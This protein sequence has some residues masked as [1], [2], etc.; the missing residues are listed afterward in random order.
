MIATTSSGRR[1]AALARYLMFGRSG[2]EPER[3]AWTA[4]R[5]V[6]TDDPE[7]AAALMQATANANLD[8]ESPVYHLTINFDPAD[9]VTP[10]R[11]QAV[12]DRVLA[13]LGLAEH[14]ALLVA[15]RDRSHPHVH[16]MVNRVHPETGRAWNRWQDRPRIERA[17][18]EL[19]R[20]LGLREVSGRLYQLDGQEPPERAPL[21]S[22]E[23]RQAER[24]GDPAFPDRVRAHLADLRAARSWEELEATLARHGL[25]LERKGQ[26]LVITDGKQQVKASRVARDLSLRRLEQ[27]FGVPYPEREPTARAREPLSRAV[28]QVTKA[29]DEHERLAALKAERARADQELAAA[30]ERLQRLNGAMERVRSASERFD[31]ALARVYK[32]PAAAR[33]RFTRTAVEIG[34]ER[35]ITLLGSEPEQFGALKTVERRRA[36]GLGVAH[37]TQPARLA[38]PSAAARARELAE[39]QHALG[40]LARSQ[41]DHTGAEHKGTE[42]EPERSAEA[43]RRQAESL[44]NKAAERLRRLQQQLKHAPSL[45]LLERSIGR[46]VDRLLP[47]EL[48]QLRRMITAP[49]AVIA[50]KA[51]EAVKDI[52]LGRE[53]GEE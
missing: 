5:N 35:A 1:F 7:V 28:E 6:G 50:F 31:A 11:M 22:G 19:E 52:L 38:A 18:R 47:R 14:Q 15:H 9:P 36:L 37:D 21:T 27:R 25:R 53:E 34:A 30:R 42:K 44:V 41:V 40:E 20:E 3:V 32:D 2:E 10:E 4:G 48:A 17:L 13:D 26:G 43:A 45:G 33:P 12:A 51:R 46:A 39:A 16:V 49:Q 29:L 23:R 8:V 24:T